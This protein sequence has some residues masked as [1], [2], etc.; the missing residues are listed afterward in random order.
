MD[1]FIGY[2]MEMEPF[3]LE[4]KTITKIWVENIVK[5]YVQN[6]LSGLIKI[7]NYVSYANINSILKCIP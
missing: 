6:I 1:I 3:S 4:K 5:R 7:I 2:N